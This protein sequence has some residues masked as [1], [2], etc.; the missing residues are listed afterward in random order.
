[1]NIKLKIGD[2]VEIVEYGNIETYNDEA[3][4]STKDSMPQ[5]IGQKGTIEIIKGIQ[6]GISGVDGKYFPFFRDQLK[7]I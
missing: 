4:I 1:M 6:Y 2:K 5:L 3:E 7:L